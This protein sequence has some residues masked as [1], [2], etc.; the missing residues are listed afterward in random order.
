MVGTA[1]HNITWTPLDESPE[2]YEIFMNGILLS[3][4]EWNGSEIIV[5]VDGYDIG[6]YNFTL[7]VR[8]VL[9]QGAA[10]SVLV[11]VV[12][13]P[14]GPSD[15]AFLFILFLLGVGVL[16]FVVTFSILYVST[17]FIQRFRKK[18]VLEDKDEIST[19]LDEIKPD[20]SEADSDIENLSN[21]DND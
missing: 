14:T 4:G 10:D 18:D 6:L 13:P 9:N 20:P 17:P 12:P 15:N 1:G 5:F 11:S 2:S 3:S 21:S 16:G 19:A 7:I 8:D